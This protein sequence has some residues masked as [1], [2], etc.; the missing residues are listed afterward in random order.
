MEGK[1]RVLIIDNEEAYC[2][3]VKLSLESTGDF[4]VS[5]CCDSKMA[6]RQVEKHKPDLVLL[7]IM[8]PGMDG[9]EIA[10]S[11]KVRDSTQH[12]PVVFLTGLISEEDIRESEGIIGGYYF[13]AKPLETEKLMDV[14]NMATSK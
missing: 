6:V 2:D 5:T 9:P 8:M 11:L 3:S 4:Q 1:K 12:I 13:V 7:E 10:T 14:I